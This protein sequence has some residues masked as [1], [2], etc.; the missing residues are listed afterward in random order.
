MQTTFS[1]YPQLVLTIMLMAVVVYLYTVIAFNFFRK[2]YTKEEDEEKE[3]NCKDMLTV[4]RDD[5]RQPSSSSLSL[6]SAS[7]FICIRVFVLVVASVTNW[8]R[9]MA[10]RWSCIESCSI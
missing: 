4:G 7:N 6:L 1:L 8:N 10:I 2:F 5:P 9:P 3:E